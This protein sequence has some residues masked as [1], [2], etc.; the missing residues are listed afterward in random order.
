M[1]RAGSGHDRGSNAMP[2]GEAELEHLLEQLP[3]EHHKEATDIVLSAGMASLCGQTPVTCIESLR[4]LHKEKFSQQKKKKGSTKASAQWRLGDT[5]HVDGSGQVTIAD[6]QSSKRNT[7]N[8]SVIDQKWWGSARSDHGMRNTLVSGNGSYRGERIYDPNAAGRR[9]SVSWKHT[10]THPNHP[11][12]SSEHDQERRKR[13]DY[14][15]LQEQARALTEQAAWRD[16]TKPPPAG[17]PS[18]S[19]SAAKA[20]EWT[21]SSLQRASKQYEQMKQE[22]LEEKRKP[23]S[24]KEKEGAHDM[25]MPAQSTQQEEADTPDEAMSSTS[26]STS[27]TSHR[28]S[29]QNKPTWKTAVRNADKYLHNPLLQSFVG[30]EF[31]A[32]VR[33]GVHSQRPRSV[34]QADNEDAEGGVEVPD[35]ADGGEN[36]DDDNDAN[37]KSPTRKM[38][39]HEPVWKESANGWLGDFSEKADSSRK[40]HPHERLSHNSKHSGR[41]L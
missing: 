29:S 30:D 15:S 8:G 4:S 17:V 7:R 22:L 31:D 12:P 1:L 16:A 39:Q 35:S 40:V 23:H 37:I 19:T 11:P 26:D 18:H 28:Q 2:E 34:V 38:Q 41:L 27:T 9:M 14:G 25:I 33:A 32:L 5:C 3:S 13:A 20:R 21:S 10:A 36:G 24:R 6:Q